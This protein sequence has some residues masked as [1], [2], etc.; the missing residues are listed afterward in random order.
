MKRKE[1]P[2]KSKKDLQINGPFK[3][4][5]M[6][7]KGRKGFLDWMRKATDAQKHFGIVAILLFKAGKKIPAVITE[8][9][10]SNLNDRFKNKL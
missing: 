8:G 5:V 1:K 4:I 7:G 10:F 3:D 6:H 9:M 2:G